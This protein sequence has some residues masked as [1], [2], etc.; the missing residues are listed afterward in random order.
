M[1]LF[2]RDAG[3]GADWETETDE[4][5]FAHSGGVLCGCIGCISAGKDDGPQ[6]MLLPTSGVAPNGKPIFSWDQAATHLTRH[7]V[8]WTF[9]P[10]GSVVVTYAFRASA[11]FS[12]PNG[13]SGFQQFSAAQIA[14]AEAA[15]ALWADVANITFVRVGGDGYSNNATI[16]FGNYT[17]GPDD[18]SGFAYY[19]WPTLTAPEAIQGDIWIDISLATNQDMTFGTFG[20]HILA[21]EIGHAIGLAHPG[22]YDGGSPTYEADAFYWQDSRAFTVMSYFGSPNVGANLPSFAGGPQLHDIA[23]IQALYGA[24]TSTR[25]GDTVYGFNSTAD[26]AHYLITSGAQGTTFAIWDGGGNDTLDL[27]GYSQNADI[28]L[29]PESFTSAGPTDTGPAVYNIAIARGVIIE[30]AIGGSGNDTIT[31]NDV[32]NTLI[33]NGG[34]DMLIGG[35]GADNLQGGAGDDV[36]T[37]G[38][39]D[40]HLNG[41]LGAD[42]IDGGAGF[43]TV[44]YDGA[45]SGVTI[46]VDAPHA[47]TGEAAGDVTISI[48]GF[49]GSIFGDYMVGGAADNVLQGFSGADILEGHGGDDLLDGGDGDDQL[50]GGLGG[51]IIDGGAGFDTARY[52]G[53]SEGVTIYVDAAYANTGEAAGDFHISIE[54]IVGSTFNDYLVGGVA[55]NVLQGFSGDDILEGHGGNDLLDGGEGNDQLNGGAGG[56]V[57]DGGA[58][59]DTVRYDGAAAG[60]VAFMTDAWANQGEAAGDAYISVEALYGSNFDD[61]LAGDGAGNEL[62][63]FDG[64]DF[65]Y[66]YGGGDFIGGGAGDDFLDGGAGADGLQGGAGAD[67]FVFRAGESDGDYIVDFDGGDGDNLLLL[68]YG[69]AAEGASLTQLDATHWQ[70]ASADGLTIDVITLVNGAVLDASDYIFGGG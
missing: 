64:T 12:M 66:G 54:G 58:G 48:E 11:P 19:P 32:A 35:G 28:D 44:R 27:S 18:I 9:T 10:G 34:A 45:A 59:F 33:G 62:Q 30:N 40:D 46:Y 24:N 4:A 60:V 21:H 63:G 5:S 16:L 49:V 61:T 2:I 51:D 69:T 57:F 7:D 52:D 67:Q 15:L 36:L 53:A 13:T 20:P 50:N 70:I 22:D 42:T 55:D 41:G 29:R 39:G 1:A 47:N 65:I 38:D 17:N 37:G 68:G 56:D 8:S 31:G 3:L 14:A 43:D 25:T 23:A 6:A 26:R